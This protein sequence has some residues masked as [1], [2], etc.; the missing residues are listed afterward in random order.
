VQVG[1][2]SRKG[3]GLALAGT[4]GVALF[5]ASLAVGSQ[6]PPR[7]KLKAGMT[8]QHTL[9]SY[10]RRMNRTAGFSDSDCW[11]YD[12]TAKIGWRHA[13]C[14]GTYSHGGT[15]YRFKFTATPIS[16]SRERVVFVVPGVTREVETRSWK[17]LVF[18]CAH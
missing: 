5:A 15:S 12:G 3:V 11:T 10:E 2:L 1:Y 13:A 6:S 14:V 8:L 17:H 7:Y 4:I 16:C 9:S 18:D